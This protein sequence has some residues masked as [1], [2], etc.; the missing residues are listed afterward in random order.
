MVAGDAVN[1]AARVQAA[2]D[3]GQVL[4]DGATQRVAESAVGF[5]GAGEHR[6]KGKTEPQRL[7]RAALYGSKTCT[8]ALDLLRCGLSGDPHAARSYSLISPPRI[9]RRRIFAAVRD[10]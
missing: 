5:V 6:L 9:L 7:W 3:P 8:T 2:A 4:V 10:Q 1:T